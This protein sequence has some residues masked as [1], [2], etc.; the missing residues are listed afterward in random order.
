MKSS[1]T[2]CRKLFF[3]NL[4]LT[5][6]ALRLGW[7]D[8]SVSS[9]TAWLKTENCSGYW[10]SRQQPARTTLSTIVVIS[11]TRFGRFGDIGCIV[12]YFGDI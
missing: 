10:G 2:P 5:L 11:S 6:K 1:V 12:I 7:L 8:H 3:K 4:L 9:P